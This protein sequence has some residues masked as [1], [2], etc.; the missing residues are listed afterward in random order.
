MS[1]WLLRSTSLAEQLYSSLFLSVL[2]KLICSM[3]FS[4]W[5]K[6]SLIVLNKSFSFK[7]MNSQ[8]IRMRSW[9]FLEP[10]IK[11]FISVNISSMSFLLSAS[12]LFVLSAVK[13]SS[14]F[15]IHLNLYLSLLRLCLNQP[16]LGD[17][18]KKILNFNFFTL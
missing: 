4:S 13:C 5:A 11:L 10:Y 17:D 12:F 14:A 18:L 9:T 7:P 16:K 15:V 8:R 6:F 1:M 2:N 3:S